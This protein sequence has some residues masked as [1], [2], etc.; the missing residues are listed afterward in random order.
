M[1]GLIYMCQMIFL[2]TIFYILI[3][4]NG[5]FS[6]KTAECLKHTSFA[7]MGNDIADFNN[8]GLP[9]IYT[10]DMLPEDNYRKKMIIPAAV[11]TNFSFCFK[12]VMN[13]NTREM[14][15]S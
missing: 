12:R 10:L 15:C 7:S 4:A 14:L 3:M 8:D 11:M 9:D 5:T 6:D 1:D 13:H 2:Q